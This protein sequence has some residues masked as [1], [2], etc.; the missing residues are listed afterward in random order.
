M[1]SG[2]RYQEIEP[3][4]L[5]LTYSEAPQAAGGGVVLVDSPAAAAASDGY[6]NQST[7]PSANVKPISSRRRLTSLTIR[8]YAGCSNDDDEDDEDESTKDKKKKHFVVHLNSFSSWSQQ[9]SA[10]KVSDIRTIVD[11]ATGRAR[12]RVSAAKVGPSPSGSACSG[13]GSSFSSSRGGKHPSS[14]ATPSGPHSTPFRP[15]RLDKAPPPPPLQ[16][17]RRPPPPPPPVSPLSRPPDRS[18]RDTGGRCRH[19]PRASVGTVA[20]MLATADAE[21]AARLANDGTA[22]AAEAETARAKPAGGKSTT[23]SGGRMR[24]PPPS[25][26]PERG[27][28]R[29]DHHHQQRRDGPDPA[30]SRRPV[31]VNPYRVAENSGSS[32]AVDARQRQREGGGGGRQRRRGKED[33]MLEGLG[34]GCRS[35][36]DFR[37]RRRGGQR[38]QAGGSSTVESS[39]TSHSSLAASSPS[40]ASSSVYTVEW[41]WPAKG[42]Q[43]QPPRLVCHYDDGTDDDVFACPT[44]IGKMGR[45]PANRSPSSHWADSGGGS[46]ARESDDGADLSRRDECRACRSPACGHAVWAAALEA[47][48]ASAQRAVASRSYAGEPAGTTAGGGGGGTA[49]TPGNC[50][51]PLFGAFHPDGHGGWIGSLLPSPPPA[52]AGSP[53]AT[54]PA[55]ASNFPTASAGGEGE[56]AVADDEDLDDLAPLPPPLPV[57]PA[58][59]RPARRAAGDVAPGQS[60][61]GGDRDSGGGGGGNDA[62]D[63]HR[64]E[65]ATV[66]QTGGWW[67]VFRSWLEGPQGTEESPVPPYT[68]AESPARAMMMAQEDSISDFLNPFSPASYRRFSASLADAGAPSDGYVSGDGF[69][70]GG[71]RD[72]AGT[73]QSSAM[74]LH[75]MAKLNLEERVMGC[76]FGGSDSPDGYGEEAMMTGQRGREIYG[77]GQEDGRREVKESEPPPACFTVRQQPPPSRLLPDNAWRLPA[78]VEN[79]LGSPAA[80][81]G[82]TTTDGLS[83]RFGTSATAATTRSAGMA[84]ARVY[85]SSPALRPP[86]TPRSSP[87]TATVAARSAWL[88]RSASDTSAAVDR[89]TARAWLARS[90]S[91]CAAAVAR[92]NANAAAYAD[93]A[94]AAATAAALAEQAS[95]AARAAADTAIEARD[96]LVFSDSVN[97]VARA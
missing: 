21:E 26:R 66:A 6:S 14:T 42:P 1:A 25:R 28:Q 81:D 64:A 3:G 7:P 58:R 17:P 46:G 36:A 92:A 56:Q 5:A 84:R 40:A 72:A 78:G 51:V 50:G 89:V 90:A 82:G 20:E 41:I 43:K 52:P 57:R 54:A 75:P 13:G 86:G 49:T 10:G 38:H 94:D 61:G 33:G 23:P 65:V 37:G 19:A 93:A 67:H 9:Q 30:R 88:A 77:A 85:R 96:A 71:G 73:R 76:V 69:F 79:A 95:V 80:T 24:R 63:H 91:D 4:G 45:L 35:G 29:R 62:G 27:Q 74:A 97:A 34:G 15:L 53:A 48:Q 39:P 44:P 22:T 55:C 8:N 32:R 12:L 31:V 70:C 60:S 47:A 68:A 83:N 18:P 16:A 59:Q 87:C 11:L 2:S